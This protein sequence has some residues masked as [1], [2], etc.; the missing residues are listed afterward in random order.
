[1]N[2]KFKFGL[3][4]IYIITFIKTGQTLKHICDICH[5]IELMNESAIQYDIRCDS[6]LKNID[7]FSLSELEFPNNKIPI[8]LNFNHL[9]LTIIT[10]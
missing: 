5:C 3:S 6:Q 1:M 4:I 8:S 7:E 10:K 9:N 2:F